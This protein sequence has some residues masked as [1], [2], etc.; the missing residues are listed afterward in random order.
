MN[1]E[2]VT[3]RLEKTVMLAQ[4]HALS[5]DMYA[6]R[7]KQLGIPAIVLSTILG[8]TTLSAFID[9]EKPIKLCVDIA[10]CVL[11]ITVAILT[12]L[13]TFFDSATRSQQHADASAKFAALAQKWELLLGAN[14]STA[15]VRELDDDYVDLI[16]KSPRVSI[17]LQNEAKQKNS[18]YDVAQYRS[19]GVWAAN[20]R[21]ESEDGRWGA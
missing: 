13:Q 4:A 3:S 17:A 14:P 19:G 8:T 12:A 2:L 21:L 9:L 6:R 16:R 11:A 20:P 7:H 15:E 10:I 1:N 5:A 18:E